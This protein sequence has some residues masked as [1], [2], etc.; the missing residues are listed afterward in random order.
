MTLKRTHHCAALTKA[1]IGQRVVLSGWINSLRNL[2]GL[3]FIDL[4]DREG[5]TQIYVDP[6]KTPAIV[7][8]MRQLRE[9]CVIS[10]AGIVQPR[11]DNMVNKTRATGGI[12]ILVDTLEIENIA[13]PMPFHLDAD[14]VNEDL[15]MK[16]RY[17]DMRRSGIVQNLRLRSRL[18]KAV[19]DYMDDNG[20]IEVETP[21]LSKSTPEGA[22]DYI[23]PSR[24]HPGLFYALPQAPQQYKQLLMVG[25]VE[26]YYQIAKCFRDEDLR[27]DRQPEFTQIDIEM[28]FVDKNDVITMVEG[29][30][31]HV[32]TAM[33][34]TEFTEPFIRMPWSE[35]MDN[36][37]SDKPDIRFGLQLKTATAIFADSAFNAFKE[38]VAAGGAI[39]ILNAEGQGTLSR[40]QID[41]LGKVAATY[42]AKGMAWL[43]LGD[44]GITGSIAKFLSE[45]EKAE[46]VKLTGAKHGDLLLIVADAKPVKAC[47]ALGQVRLA[48]ASQLGLMDPNKFCFLW[49]ID[50]PLL[51]WDEEEKHFV[52]VHH[53]FTSALDEDLALMESD[54]GKVR[55]KAYDIVLNGVEL[56]GGSIRIHRSDRQKQMFDLLGISDDEA[57]P[58]FG[59]ILEAFSF[60]APPHGG[61]AIGLDRFVMLMVGATSIKDVMAFPKTNKAACV[62]MNAPSTVDAKQLRE[63]NIASTATPK[64]D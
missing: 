51:D 25:G 27:A 50:F 13:A 52:P 23:V 49:V 26:R 61:L 48:L 29:M 24:V 46:I 20:F 34:G 56:G 37:G 36:Y 12:E 15:R 5:I 2:G 22:R 17:L 43:K 18:T 30:V 55:A 32:F 11:P 58:R 44:D 45:T 64:V 31:K 41:D 35:A 40:K 47:T 21:I 54:P 59:H 62:M 33:K 7:E 60:G 9:E 14:N 16:Y 53:P 63:L 10:I 57:K 6:E 38:V 42:G 19:R 3:A 4:R 28:S 1:D 8:Q 39:K